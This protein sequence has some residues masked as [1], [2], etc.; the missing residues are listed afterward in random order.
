MTEADKM[1]AGLPYDSRDPELLGLYH[2]ARRLL[3]A[4]NGCDSDAAGE[5]SRILTELLGRMG[6]G[7]WIEPPFLCD[8]GVNITIGDHTFINANCLFVDDNRIEIGRNG[9]IAPNVQIHTASHPVR[10]DERIV[11]T[12]DGP[13]YVTTTAPVVIGD[14]VWIGGGTVILPGVRIGHDVTIGAGSVV[15]RDIPD[16]VLAFG[17]PCRVQ[18]E[19]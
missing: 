1:L 5:R 9:L 6:D 12:A 18:R 13:R 19:L 16:R 11:E 7:V 14:R 15:T 10:A 2:R 8:Y 4:Y 17:N 3:R